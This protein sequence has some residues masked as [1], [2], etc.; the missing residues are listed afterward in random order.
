M[1]KRLLTL[2]TLLL[3]LATF[4]VT[5]AQE[6]GTASDEGLVLTEAQIKADFSIPSTTA[7]QISNLEVDVKE[8]GLHISFQMTLTRNGKSNT[9]NIIAVLI[10]LFAQPRVSSLMLENTMISGYIISPALRDE[11]TNLV[12]SSWNG[13]EAT[14]LVSLPSDQIPTQGIIMR[15]GGICDP[16]RHMGC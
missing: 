2:I 10:G 6:K 8:D 5:Q 1:S 11:V 14:V 13:Y 15:D 12:L 4:S 9:L 7:R 16:I 3:L